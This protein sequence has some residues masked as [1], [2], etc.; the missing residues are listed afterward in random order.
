MNNKALSNQREDVNFIKIVASTGKFHMEV[1]EGTEGAIIREGEV[2]G[3]EFRKVEQTF[4][5]L[6]GKIKT[7]DVK[8]TDWGTNLYIKIEDIVLGLNT[9]GSFAQD[10]MKKIPNIDLKQEVLLQPYSFKNE[11]DKDVRGVTVKQNG[12]KILNYFFDAEAKKELHGYPV[13]PKNWKKY[14]KDQWKVFGISVK[15][16]LN[17]YTLENHQYFAEPIEAE[18]RA[19]EDKADEDFE[20]DWGD[21][22]EEKKVPTK[23][24]KATK[25]RK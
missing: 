8:D 4:D 9:D 10:L 18:I 23:K 25:K 16:F 12:E 5:T 21:D 14:T 20:G 22:K 11:K 17:E 6:A 1:P 13:F 3:K 15:T 24:K 2:N 7:I 19:S